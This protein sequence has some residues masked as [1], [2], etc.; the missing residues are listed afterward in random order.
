M[1]NKTAKQTTSNNDD[2]NHRASQN[3]IQKNLHLYRTHAP[4]CCAPIPDF[5]IN[6]GI[7]SRN[8]ESSFF[9][10]RNETRYTFSDAVVGCVGFEDGK[11]QIEPSLLVVFVSWLLLLYLPRRHRTMHLV[12][13]T[14][15]TTTSRRIVQRAAGIAVANPQYYSNGGVS[16]LAT[17]TTTTTTGT[18]LLARPVAPAASVVVG[19]VQRSCNFSSAS[20]S[21]S[22][23]SGGIRGWMEDRKTRK[24]QDQYMEQMER[25]STMDELTLEN[26][27]VELERGLSGIAAKLSFLQTKEV[28]TAKEIIKVVQCF[29]DV[30][31]NQKATAE[32]LIQMD[33]LTRLKVATTANKTVEEIA[34]MVSQ[35]Q[36]MDLMQRTLKKRRLE[37]KPIPENAQSMQQAIQKDALTVMTKSQKEMMKSR[38][39]S[40][41]KRMARKRR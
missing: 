17:T 34:I 8:V 37:G 13:S 12:K 28:E 32:D 25:L 20:S 16:F 39:L 22:S 31:G 6:D 23:S 18:A 15:I 30:L 33:R 11:G 10:I 24:E 27:K 3:P 7:L 40:H 38:Q 4:S 36:N 41:A 1:P 29:I 26:Y 19:M 14:F 21:S 35:I 2:H 9:K 5:E